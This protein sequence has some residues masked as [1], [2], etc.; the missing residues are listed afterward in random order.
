MNKPGFCNEKNLPNFSIP[1][2]TCSDQ[3]REE[4]E[5]M[6]NFIRKLQ[7]DQLL[8]NQMNDHS[9]NTMS[10]N[11]QAHQLNLTAIKQELDDVKNAIKRQQEQLLE[12]IQ[13]TT[14]KDPVNQ[15]NQAEIV[16]F[17]FEIDRV[18]MQLK[19]VK[20]CCLFGCFHRT[21]LKIFVFDL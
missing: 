21:W 2:K 9:F 6:K 4:L 15:N 14:N 20:F 16:N 17:T 3:I 19:K 10:Q 5:S 7:D 13:A 12:K 8:A 1:L 18:T 11:N